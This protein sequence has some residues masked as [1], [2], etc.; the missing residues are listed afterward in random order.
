M[1]Y[2]EAKHRLETEMGF[3][4]IFS[5]R[6]GVPMGEL[7]NRI[8]A[9]ESGCPPLNILLVRQQD[10]LPGIGAGPFIADYLG[11]ERF[12]APQVRNIDTVEWRAT[13]E[14][15]V[16]HVYAFEGWANVYWRA[17]GNHLPDYDPPKGGEQDGIRHRRAGEG[18]RHKDLRLWVKDNPVALDSDYRTFETQTEFV[19]DSADRVDV[20]YLGPDLTVAIEVKSSD[21]DNID[22]KRGVFQCIKYRAVMRAMDFRSDPRVTAIL[23]TQTP[24]PRDLE[25]LR[26]RHGIRH[27]KAPLH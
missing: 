18:Q 20:V 8:L 10:R 15:L 17:F 3:D 21:S 14:R 7:M 2:G 26:R 9:V 1:T 25:A 5:T 12:R 16:A 4:T 23:V 24:L 27:F 19:L 11:D 13:C 22:L 6:M